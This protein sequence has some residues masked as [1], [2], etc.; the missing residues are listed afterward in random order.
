MNEWTNV[1]KNCSS[2]GGEKASQ[3]RRESAGEVGSG[4]R[5]VQTLGCDFVLL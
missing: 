4:L 3:H 1:K 2:D 5:A